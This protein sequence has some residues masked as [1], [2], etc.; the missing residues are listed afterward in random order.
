VAQTPTATVPRSQTEVYGDFRSIITAINPTWEMGGF[1][2]PDGTVWKYREPNATVIVEGDR[3]RVRANPLTRSHDKLQVLDNAKHMYYSTA[4]FSPPE[5]GQISLE[6]SIKARVHNGHP[7]DLYDGIVSVNLLDFQT[8]AA[9]DF[10]ASNDKLATVYGRVFFPGVNAAPP[11]D[12][13]RPTY[14]CIFNELSV[15]TAPGQPHLYR[16]TYDKARD[17]LWW[18]IDGEEVDHHASVPM[19]IDSFLIALG[20]MTEKPIDENKS[21]SLHGQGLTGEWSPIRVIKTLR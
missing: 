8:G 3:L 12:L 13:N 16:I 9:I 5:D 15:P 19:K 4:R 14:F 20:L 2:L 18:H 7:G 1:T 21:T 6:L 10:F 17:E 11:T